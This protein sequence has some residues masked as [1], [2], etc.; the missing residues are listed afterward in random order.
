MLRA[1]P[2]TGPLDGGNTVTLE[3]AGFRAGAKVYF[4]GAPGTSVN[5]LASTALTVTAPSQAASGPVAIRV[6]LPP[7]AGATTGPAYT[8]DDAYTYQL[9]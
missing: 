8:L 6:E 2:A 3:G 5:V 7:L 9:G 4:G 1:I